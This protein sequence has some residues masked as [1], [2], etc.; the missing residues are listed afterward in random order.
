[1]NSFLSRIKRLE[2]NNINKELCESKHKLD[3]EKITNLLRVTSKAEELNRD[4]HQ[5]LKG[6]L[7]DIYK[8]VDVIKNCVHK[9]SGMAG[10]KTGGDK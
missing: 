5:E 9:L 6:Q 3:E 7:S 8:T 10:K 1:M 2:D 4:D